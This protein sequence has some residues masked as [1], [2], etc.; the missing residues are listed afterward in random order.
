MYIL[1]THNMS[2]LNAI[3][4][5]ITIVIQK[6]SN[7]DLCSIKKVSGLAS[8]SHSL[9]LQNFYLF[10]GNIHVIILSNKHEH[11][12]LLYEEATLS[13][14]TTD[15]LMHPIY[16]DRMIDD[17]L[18]DSWSFEHHFYWMNDTYAITNQVDYKNWIH[19]PIYLLD[20]FVSGI[21]N[22]LALWRQTYQKCTQE[23]GAV[24]VDIFFSCGL[25]C[26]LEGETWRK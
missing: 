17:K 21:C 3:C 16:Y 1:R 8:H 12:T 23:C 18:T 20:C 6:K 11:H 9:I 2:W 10:Y 4:Q 26:S 15:F 5:P 19:R 24:S 13:P 22:F 25:V 14:F 7:R